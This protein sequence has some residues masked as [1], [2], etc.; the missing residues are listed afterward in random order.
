MSQAVSIVKELCQSKDLLATLANA[1]ANSLN[2][3]ISL[4]PNHLSFRFTSLNLRIDTK[5]S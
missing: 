4:A 3:D 2:D 5:I 1:I